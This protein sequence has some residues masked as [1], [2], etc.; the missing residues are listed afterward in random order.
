MLRDAREQ[1]GAWTPLMQHDDGGHA[2]PLVSPYLSPPPG[3]TQL[4]P[5]RSTD[6]A[7][8][9]CGTVATPGVSI[10]WVARSSP[11]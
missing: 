6:T 1:P 11:A 7:P 10:A 8:L 2:S 5:P 4:T 3:P 9:N